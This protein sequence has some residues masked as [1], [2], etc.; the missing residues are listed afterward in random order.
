MLNVQYW[1]GEMVQWIKELATESDDRVPFPGPTW[2]RKS[3][4][5][6]R[7]LHA[8]TVIHNKQMKVKKI[9]KAFGIFISM[10]FVHT[11]YII[12]IFSIFIKL[13]SLNFFLGSYKN[14]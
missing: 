7:L 1:A 14:T 9:L 10:E 11:A 6:S 4:E 8:C 3:A 2:W 13:L 5:S 12:K